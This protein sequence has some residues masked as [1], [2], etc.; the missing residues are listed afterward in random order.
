M[1]MLNVESKGEKVD[2]CLVSV[3]PAAPVLTGN[4]VVMGRYRTGLPYCRFGIRNPRAV[5]RA[6]SGR[7]SGPS[8]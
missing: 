2:E 6:P 1:A 3:Q 4:A 7:T 8:T 5:G